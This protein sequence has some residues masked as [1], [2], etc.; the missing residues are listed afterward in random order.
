[1][2]LDDTI[3]AIATPLMP[4]GIGVIRI[5][6]EKAI[7]LVDAVFRGT[8]LKKTESHKLVYGWIID[9]EKLIDK[10]LVVVMRAPNSYTAENVVEIQTHGSPFVLRGILDLILNRGARL[11]EA[12]EF[13]QRA[14]L[15]G[16]IDLTQAEAISD[17][18]HSNS[19]IGA[20]IAANQ[21]SGKLFRAIDE[22]KKKIVYIASIVEANI[23]FPEEIESFTRRE[24]CLEGLKQASD[25]L[26]QLIDN[27]ELGEKIREGFSVTLIGRPNVGKSSLLNLLIGEQR[28]IVTDIPGTTRDS[29]EE[30]V[31]IRGIPFRLT[32]TAGIR[33][34]N[35]PIESEGIRRTKISREKADYILLILDA[36]EELKE[37]DANLI[38]EIEKTKTLVL[39]NKIDLMKEKNI[40]W[41][42]SINSLDYIFVSAKNGE[43]IQ[44][45]KSIL[46]EKATLGSRLNQD[47][48]WITNQRQLQAAKH[49]I[50]S[51]NLARKVLDEYNGEELLAVDLKSCLNAL[52]EIVGETTPDDLLE[53]IFSEFCIGK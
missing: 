25:D 20:K 23:E 21:M 14:F 7:T 9:Q 16:R 42:D 46:Y 1:M 53:N 27:A 11:A 45:L 36:S 24:E 15:N 37:E 12:G 22:V 35:D 48:F 2:R 18:I 4:S 28:A 3:A 32:D 29:I 8:P 13:T 6:G 31:Q 38:S 47:E 10:V 52:G 40:F 50:N 39:I 30:F 49:A 41:Q 5:S 34:A 17:L 19:E 43:G 26:H 44:Q 51:L 33:E